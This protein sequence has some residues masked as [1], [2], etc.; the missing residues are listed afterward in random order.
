MEHVY[1]EGQTTKFPQPRRA[2]VRTCMTF[3]SEKG[4]PR[5]RDLIT[6]KSRLSYASL[7]LE[8]NF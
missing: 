8:T 4:A 1:T 3:G 5:R 7:G 6:P 2:R